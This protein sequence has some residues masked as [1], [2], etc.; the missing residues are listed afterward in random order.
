MSAWPQLRAMRW[1]DEQAERYYASGVWTR[2]GLP[3]LLAAQPPGKVA[4]DDG[5]EAVGYGEL[6]ERL[7]GVATALRE[8]GVVEGAVV[9]VRMGNTIGHV[10]LAYAVAA[11]G[12][13][14]F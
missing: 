13:V 4:F 9:A 10:V 6:N 8:R 2:D 14:L 12:G 5:H 7:R 11:A 1:S 3:A